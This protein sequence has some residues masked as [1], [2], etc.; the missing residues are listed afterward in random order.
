MQEYER[1]YNALNPGVMIDND[2]DDAAAN[3]ND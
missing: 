3:D 1:I 2:D